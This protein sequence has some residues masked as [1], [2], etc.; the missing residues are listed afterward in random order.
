MSGIWGCQLWDILDGF[1]RDGDGCELDSGPSR[2]AA[3]CGT[4]V[5]AGR[6]SPP[7]A[8][9]MIAVGGDDS[10]VALKLG[11]RF[12]GMYEAEWR[13]RWRAKRSARTNFCSH[14]AATS[15][16]TAHAKIHP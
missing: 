4:R 10:V 1:G 12:L 3:S 7:A 14:C 16:N 6:A 2:M 11:S 13:F 5:R 8:G 15:V 9:E